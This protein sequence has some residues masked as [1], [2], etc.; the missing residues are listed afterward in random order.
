MNFCFYSNWK[1]VHDGELIK[2]IA[3]K[4]EKGESYQRT[5]EAVG[6]HQKNERNKL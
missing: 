5:S 1:N 4:L 3:D 6:I 2:E